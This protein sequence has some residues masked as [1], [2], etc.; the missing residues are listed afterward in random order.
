MYEE[1]LLGFIKMFASPQMFIL[2]MVSVVFYVE[3]TKEASLRKLVLG[4][5]ESSP[6]VF[7]FYRLMWGILGGALIS[8]LAGV[9][10]IGF[11]AYMDVQ[12]IFMLTAFALSRFSMYVNL[13]MHILGV[14]LLKYLLQENLLS[15]LD[16]IH[17]YLLVGISL[18]VQGLLILLEGEKG[19]LPVILSRDQ[20]IR[21][22]FQVKK[23]FMLPGVLGFYATAGTILGRAL[24]FLPLFQFFSLRETVMTFS[25]KQSLQVFSGLKILVGSLVLLSAY[26]VSF[27]MEWTYLLLPLVPMILFLEKGVYR[28]LERRR[29][30]YFISTEEEI[31]VLEVHTKSKA[32]E[33][34]LRSGDRLVEV[35][36]RKPTYKSVV[37]FLGTLSY[38]RPVSLKARGEDGQAKELSFLIKPGTSTGILVV[39]P[40]GEFFKMKAESS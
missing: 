3:E 13:G 7:T 22:G 15:S 34:G 31:V 33:E 1:I 5:G 27:F 37:A 36:G 18:M 26:V 16:L 8:I 35:D 23:S 14:F 11:Y 29:K 10:H 20:E 38:E 24:F 39:P 19:Y 32:Y 9:F 30:P 17:M 40:S 12:I 28:L 2:L 4:D 6:L 21:G 25:K